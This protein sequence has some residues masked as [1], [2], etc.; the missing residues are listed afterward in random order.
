MKYLLNMSLKY[1]KTYAT[2]KMY[3]TSAARSVAQLK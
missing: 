2:K 1:T 3:V